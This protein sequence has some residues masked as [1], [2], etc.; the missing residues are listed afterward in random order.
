M[1]IIIVSTIGLPVI[2]DWKAFVEGMV[3]WSLNA[4]F[5]IVKNENNGLLSI[6]R[7]IL[8]IIDVVLIDPLVIKLYNNL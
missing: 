5:K 3:G 1:G 6:S 8:L 7:H 4:I 2:I